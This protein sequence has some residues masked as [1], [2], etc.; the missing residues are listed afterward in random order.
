MWPHGSAEWHAGSGV[1]WGGLGG[2]QQLGSKQGDEFILNLCPTLLSAGR[3]KP[4]GLRSV[5][6]SHICCVELYGGYKLLRWQSPEPG[7][8]DRRLQTENWLK[9]TKH[10]ESVSGSRTDAPR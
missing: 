4:A 1:E 9:I 8:G 6:L 5:Q 10:C 3:M 2:E 7:G